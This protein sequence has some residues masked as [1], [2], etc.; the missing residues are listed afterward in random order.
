MDNLLSVRN[1][2]HVTPSAYQ[3]RC[4]LCNESIVW[5]SKIATRYKP[6]PDIF[7]A[8]HCRDCVITRAVKNK[9]VRVLLHAGRNLGREGVQSSRHFFLTAC[10][11]RSLD[12]RG[13]GCV[14]W[15]HN[16][17]LFSRVYNNL[18]LSKCVVLFPP[19]HV[20]KIDPVADCSCKKKK[21]LF[22]LLADHVQDSKIYTVK[23]KYARTLHGRFV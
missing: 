18:S 11:A 8:N 19:P 9:L 7:L 13:R 22:Y 17:G 21:H 20:M 3:Q 16:Y 15:H 23:L 12:E 4:S 5:S 14:E 1:S 6:R 2:V 10:L